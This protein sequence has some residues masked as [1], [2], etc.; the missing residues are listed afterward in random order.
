[1]ISEIFWFGAA[2]FAVFL[3]RYLRW[4][5][6]PLNAL[7]G[8]IQGKTFREWV[9]GVFP[10]IE[11][12]PFMQPQQRWWEEAGHDTQLLHYTGILGR[13]FVCVLD[14]DGVKKILTSK[15][16]VER[17]FFVKGMYYVK[18]VIGDGLVTLDG[19]KWHLH[20][21]I[22]QPS[23]HNQILRE[24]LDSCVPE[25]AAR[26]IR[27]WKEREGSDIDIASHFSAL[28]LDIIGKVAF[29]HEFKSMEVVEQWARDE[30]C[31]VELKDPL[32]NALYSSMTP[33]LVKMLLINL[34]L[35]PLERYLIPE[36]HATQTILN[37][38]VA[39]VVQRTHARYINR[40][41]ADTKPKCLLELLFDAEDC[42]L[43]PKNRSLTHK[44]LQEETKTFLVAG[45]ET[46]STLCVWAIYCLT[47]YPHIQKLVFDDIMKHAP[48]NS[49]ATLESLDNMT[50][51]DAFLNEVLRLYPP[52]GMI[53]RNTSKCV[54][55]LGVDIPANTRIIIPITLLQ[56]HPKYWTDPECFKPERW[57]KTEEPD[58]KHHHFAYLPF[59]AGGRNCIGQRFALWEAKLILAPIIRQF[60][61]T[62]SPSLAGVNRKLVS[63]VTIKSVPPVLDGVFGQQFSK[64]APDAAQ[65]VVFELPD[66]K[67]CMALNPQLHTHLHMSI[68]GPYFDSPNKS[69]GDRY[70]NVT[71]ICVIFLA[72]TSYLRASPKSHRAIRPVLC[73]RTLLVFMSRCTNQRSCTCAMADNIWCIMCFASDCAN[74]APARG[75]RVIAAWRSISMHSMTMNALS[76][77]SP[78]TISRTVTTHSW[79]SERRTP[80]SRSA[81]M[82]KPSFVMSSSNL[83]CLMATISPVD[84]SRPF[85]TTP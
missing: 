47:E 25:L 29:S 45:H 59:S 67:K 42:E 4:R 73:T 65:R 69:S 74:G 80:I 84:L 62:I 58:R 70:H 7:P 5:F 15:A 71:T 81:E 24:S 27:A 44:E 61:F 48:R 38:A 39:D 33:S 52:V 63:F 50:Y 37:Q 83:I 66:K 1:M 35:S 78:T 56:R 21:R 12:E 36:A 30:S 14:A 22:I 17:P 75:P 2:C 64:D 43:G 23:F 32:I 31:E 51:V 55:L 79:L 34:R 11:K 18:R 49:S 82:G 41:E 26:M 16:E 77:A 68:S 53:V 8:P 13:H 20:R 72:G 6:H 46:V 60:Q 19:P 57:L 40:E 10:I 3:W 28:T 76:R 85:Q 9:I 54:P